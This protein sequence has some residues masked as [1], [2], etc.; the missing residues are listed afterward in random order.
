[1][2]WNGTDFTPRD[3]GFVWKEVSRNSA[4]KKETS[5]HYLHIKSGFGMTGF[6]L[7]VNYFINHR[8]AL[9]YEHRPLSLKYLRCQCVLFISFIEA[10]CLPKYGGLCWFKAKVKA[11]TDRM[12]L[13][14]PETLLTHC[15][16]HSHTLT[17]TH[18]HT[19]THGD[20]EADNHH[21]SSRSFHPFLH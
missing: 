15:D 12:H 5:S 21:S 3:Q 9:I 11:G 19:H 17:H 8:D 10:E 14:V 18:T 13:S 20:S 16:Q 6:H 4:P 1:M 7:R 2:S